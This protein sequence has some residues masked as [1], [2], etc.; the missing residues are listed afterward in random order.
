MVS[1]IT[2]ACM[3]ALC[4]EPM[5]SSPEETSLRYCAWRCVWLVSLG[6]I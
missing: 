2:P 1:Q 4:T 5:T 3:M 6:R